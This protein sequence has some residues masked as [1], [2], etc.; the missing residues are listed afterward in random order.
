MKTNHETIGKARSGAERALS[1]HSH[2]S[3]LLNKSK[4]VPIDGRNEVH[5]SLLIAPGA[6]NAGADGGAVDVS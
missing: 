2:A 6:A 3:T 1:P 4:G 5:L